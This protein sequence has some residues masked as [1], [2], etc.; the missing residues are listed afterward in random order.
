[1]RQK[2]DVIMDEGFKGIGVIRVLTSLQR[3]SLQ[4]TLKF[5]KETETLNILKILEYSELMFSNPT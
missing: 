4:I 1:M 3:G 2:K 5:L